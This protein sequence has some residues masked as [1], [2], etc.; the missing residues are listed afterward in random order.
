MSYGQSRRSVWKILEWRDGCVYK[1]ELL[2]YIWL[3]EKYWSTP[4]EKEIAKQFGGDML[5]SV[6][7][8]F[9]YDQTMRTITEDGRW[10]DGKLRKF[11]PLDVNEP[12]LVKDEIS[13]RVK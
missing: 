5:G 1:T 2:G 9:I 3:D 12:K 6:P 11:V 7:T 4:Y 13:R 8:S 10:F